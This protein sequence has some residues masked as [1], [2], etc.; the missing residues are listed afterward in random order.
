MNKISP[1]KRNQILAVILLALGAIAGLYFG[2]LK[3]QSARLASASARSS[4]FAHKI[5]QADSLLRSSAQAEAALRAQQAFLDKSE[6]GMASGDIY[7]WLINTLND[8]NATRR[9]AIADFQRESLGVAGLLPNFPYQAALF[10]I[11]GSGYFHDIGRFLADFE[12]AFPFFRVQNL[13]L[14]PASKPGAKSG[15]SGLAAGS[16]PDDLLNFSFQIVALI[17]PSVK[18]LAAK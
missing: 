17:K 15:S 14:S 4:A 18:D 5:S 8:F 10:P 9:V 1:Q 16:A 12:N 2:L 11:R 13:E 6:Q 7:L 3:P